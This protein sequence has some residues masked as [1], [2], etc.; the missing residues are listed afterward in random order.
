M[1]RFAGIVLLL[2]FSASSSCSDGGDDVVVSA[3]KVIVTGCKK[4]ESVG[5]CIDELGVST[6]D[7]L[8]CISSHGCD[9][10]TCQADIPGCRLPEYMLDPK[11]RIDPGPRPADAGGA[12]TAPGPSPIEAGPNG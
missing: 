3:C 5:Q 1:R 12:D 11:D 2:A 8:A 9:Y 7:C 6:G 4:G 10:A